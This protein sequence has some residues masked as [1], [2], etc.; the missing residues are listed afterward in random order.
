MMDQL[1]VNEDP[2]LSRRLQSAVSN[3][4]MS[5]S[6]QQSAVSNSKNFAR[7]GDKRQKDVEESPTQRQQRKR[8][9]LIDR[10]HEM[11]PLKF[12]HPQNR[13]LNFT[14]PCCKIKLT[15]SWVN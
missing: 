8:P 3:Q 5:L 12:I 4:F 10:N 11:V 9:Y 2:S 6:S 15:A 7:G 13:Q 14:V 1:V